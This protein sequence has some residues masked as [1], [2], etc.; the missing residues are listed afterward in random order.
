M[1]DVLQMCFAFQCNFYESKERNQSYC[2]F[3]V[4]WQDSIVG[5]VYKVF[6]HFAMEM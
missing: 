1:S 3:L 5:L 2:L 4:A 6:F